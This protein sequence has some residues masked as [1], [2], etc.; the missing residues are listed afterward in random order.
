[1]RLPSSASLGDD[2]QSS[3]VHPRL[4]EHSRRSPHDMD[5]RTFVA[6]PARASNCPRSQTCSPSEMKANHVQ[7][8]T[9]G[10]A[11]G[12]GSLFVSSFA[13]CQLRQAATWAQLEFV[14]FSFRF[15]PMDHAK[16]A[17]CEGRRATASYRIARHRPCRCEGGHPPRQGYGS[18]RAHAD[19]QNALGGI[20]GISF[21]P[22]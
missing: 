17:S 10:R 12:W 19:F 22:V 7:P 14:S 16:Y 9:A 2:S 3:L 5:E 15:C 21:P 18:A 13:I 8:R 11:G 1:M 6:L 4:A 20:F